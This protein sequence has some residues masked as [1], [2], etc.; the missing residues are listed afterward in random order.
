MTLV[1]DHISHSEIKF[2]ELSNYP[3]SCGMWITFEL[4]NMLMKTYVNYLLTTY[5]CL[6]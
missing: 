4:K 3:Q 1:E 2:G 6:L 5:R